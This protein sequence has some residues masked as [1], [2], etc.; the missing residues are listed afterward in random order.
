MAKK[1]PETEPTDTQRTR[2]G[3]VPV[4]T[5]AARRARHLEDGATRRGERTRGA[6]LAAAREV[7]EREGFLTARVEDIAKE[8][9]V[10]HGSF[11]TYFSSK[12][13]VLREITRSVGVLIEEAVSHV[14]HD[15]TGD[16]M[17]ALLRS[18]ERYLAVYREHHEILAVIEQVATV[19]PEIH[20][21]RL[22]RRRHHVERVTRTIRRWQEEGR[23]DADLDAHTVA[24]ALVSMLSNFAYWW[25]AGGDDYDESTVALTV[26]TIWARAVGLR[27]GAD[28]L[29]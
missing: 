4:G 22:S 2:G 7:F 23:A 10:A 18:N 21:F 8:A 19:D 29:I 17:A 27:E 9:G 16:S 24:G 6:I 12:Q 3:W 26:S 5:A 20:E 14:P 28:L 11:Y 25:L 13:D 15:P 1:S